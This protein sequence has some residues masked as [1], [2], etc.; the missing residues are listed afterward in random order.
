MVTVT[1]ANF[2]DTVEQ[3]KV[4]VLLDVWAAWCTP[5]RMMEPILEELDGELEGQLVIGKLN[6]DE[7]PELTQHLGVMSLPTFLLIKDGKIV[8]GSV[9][10]KPKSAVTAEI[11]QHLGIKAA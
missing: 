11:A 6:A 9:G 7:E 10:A 8:H 4:P 2:K 3:S 1:T 5:C